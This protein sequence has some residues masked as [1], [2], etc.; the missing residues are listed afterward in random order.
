M[1][2][3]LHVFRTLNDNAGALLHDPASGA[4]AA[5]DVP[6]AGEMLAAAKA[7]GWTI[8]DIF[9]T[10]AHGTQHAASGRLLDPVGNVATARFHIKL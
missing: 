8:S 1:P 4:C 7:K 2:L 5:V 9:I 3:D 10:H 6:D